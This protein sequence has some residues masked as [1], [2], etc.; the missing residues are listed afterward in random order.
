MKLGRNQLIAIL[1]GAV[2]IGSAAAGL[3]LM[4]PEKAKMFLDFLD[5][6]GRW[7]LTTVIG[8]SAGIKVAG[9]LRN[10]KQPNK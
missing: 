8:C 4:E 6:F 7:T 10:G 5:S 9:L 2:I 1:G 3:G